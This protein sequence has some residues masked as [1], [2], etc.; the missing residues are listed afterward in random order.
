MRTNHTNYPRRE[1]NS[2][3]R[4]RKPPFYPLNY[5]DRLLRIVDFGLRIGESDLQLFLDLRI[6]QKQRNLTVNR[7]LNITAQ[8]SCFE[9]SKPDLN[10]LAAIDI[11]F[12]KNDTVRGIQMG[13]ASACSV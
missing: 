3:L 9:S 1:S 4:F 11:L 10:E 8:G 6:V 13:E 12:V 7:R 2:H 5:G